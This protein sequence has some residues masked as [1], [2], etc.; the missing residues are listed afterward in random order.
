MIGEFDLVK[1]PF[2][3]LMATGS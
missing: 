2:D 3:K 1:P